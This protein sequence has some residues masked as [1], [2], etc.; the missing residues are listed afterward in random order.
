MQTS[1]RASNSEETHA[2]RYETSALPTI[3]CLS[4]GFTPQRQQA[5]A[6]PD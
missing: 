6:E 4:F 1:L 5:S 2:P 3:A